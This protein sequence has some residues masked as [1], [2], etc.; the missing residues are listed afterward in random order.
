MKEDQLD[1]IAEFIN[2]VAENIDDEYAIEEVGKE[3]ILLSSQFAIPE[4][5]ICAV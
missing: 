5:F 1:K 2:R 3:A 4:H